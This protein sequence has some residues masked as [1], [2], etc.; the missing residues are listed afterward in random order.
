MEAIDQ[1]RLQVVN[2]WGDVED[3]ADEASGPARAAWRHLEQQCALLYEEVTEEG[4]D[5]DP[6]L[7]D[8]AARLLELRTRARNLGLSIEVDSG[9]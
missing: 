9:Q 4:V 3:A 5:H 1:L 6:Y 7:R 8:Y 2:L